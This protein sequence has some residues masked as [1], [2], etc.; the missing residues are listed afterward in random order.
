MT[1]AWSSSTFGVRGRWR[2]RVNTPAITERRGV[3]VTKRPNSYPLASNHHLTS[4]RTGCAAMP[5]NSGSGRRLVGQPLLYSIS[6]FA[7]LGVFLVCT[8]RLHSETRCLIRRLRSSDMTKG[9]HCVVNYP[10]RRSDLGCRVMSGIITGPHF[11]SYFKEP[12][13]VETGT[14]VAVLEIGAFSACA[15]PDTRLL[16]ITRYYSHFAC[17]RKSR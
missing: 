4:P 12:G 9:K 7:S 1:W 3:I 5:S 15:Y 14:M 16:Q 10:V 2:L 8:S 6:I 17:C 13:P 11:R